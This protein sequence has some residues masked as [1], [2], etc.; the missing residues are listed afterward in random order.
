MSNFSIVIVLLYFL[1]LISIFFGRYINIKY[2]N[3]FSILISLITFILAS[4]RPDTFPD[5]DTYEIIFDSASVGD[6]NN[7]SYWLL[8]GE[9]GFKIIIYILHICGIEFKGFLIF[10]S[11]LSFSLLVYI[12]KISKIA[13]TY[14]WFTY[15]SFYFITRDL[16]IIRLSIASHLIVLM[17]LRKKNISKILILIFTS[18]TFQYFAIVAILAPIIARVSMNIR[19]IIFLLFIS[20]LLSKYISFDNL[21]FLTPEKQLESYNGTS[22]VSGGIGSS[23][24][25]IIRNL[26][27][28]IVLFLLFR[29]KINVP[30]YNAWIWSGILSVFIYILTANILVISQ[31]FSAYFGAIIPVAFSFKMDKLNSVNQTFLLL[32]FLCLLNFISVFYYNDFIWR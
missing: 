20:Y 26:F 17:F 22:Q 31:R 4:V 25:A 5:V 3:K 24:S 27:F 28:S 21:V 32:T 8:H 30:F 7:E 29:K 10:M 1:C 11:L 12:S 2:A 18:I 14:L 23:L 15:F 9:P 16:G 6:F 13:F 19:I